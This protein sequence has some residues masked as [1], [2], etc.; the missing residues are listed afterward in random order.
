MRGSAILVRLNSPPVEGAANQE[1]I[2]LLAKALRIAKGSISIIGGGH[3]RSKTV[4]VLGLTP[5]QVRNLL[6]L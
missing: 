3:N 5:E 2:E 1:L 6:N 4:R